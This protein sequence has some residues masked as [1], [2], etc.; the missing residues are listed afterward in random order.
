[1]ASVD[2]DV[3]CAGSMVTGAGRLALLALPLNTGARPLASML[4]RLKSSLTLPLTVTVWPTWL[5]ARSAGPSPPTK[6]P[7]EVA[8]LA[9]W[10]AVGVST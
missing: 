8:G 2:W 5:A 3:A 6:M 10:S 1:M 4:V 7:S 9:S